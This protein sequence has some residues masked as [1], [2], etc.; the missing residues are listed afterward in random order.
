[1]VHDDDYDG[2][3]CTTIIFNLIE[4]MDNGD[5]WDEIHES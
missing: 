3:C 4:D 5:S 2:Y 1:M